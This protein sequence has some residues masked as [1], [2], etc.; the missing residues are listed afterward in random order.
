MIEPAQID[1]GTPGEP[2]RS[3]RHGDLYHPRIG[4]LEQARHV[5]LAGNGLPARWA[6]RERFTV[7][8]L[9]FGL[10]N[11]FLATWQAWRD[12]A[13]RCGRLVFVSIEKHPPRH[14]DLSRAHE[15]SPLPALAAALV[16][17]WPPLVPGMHRL[18]FEGGR[19]ELLLA[20][21]DVRTLLPRLR[22]QADAVF[23]DGFAP[24]KNPA[25]NATMW[26]PEV[27]KALAR[28]AAPGA[29]AATWSAAG[30]LRAALSAAGFEWQAAPGIGGKREI[31]QARFAPRFPVPAA[32]P[33]P[34][35]ALV[36]G[37][38]LA[39]ASAAR[40]LAQ[41]GVAVTVLEAA[42][43]AAAGAS[44]SPAGLFHG[45]VHRDDGPYARLF[46]AAAL[47]AAGE[48]AR[49]GFAPQGLLRLV[50]DD[51]PGLPATAA[52]YA[53]RV[54]GDDAAQLAGVPV[55]GPAWYFEGG[56]FVEPARWVQKALA[57]PGVTLR[58]QARAGRIGRGDDGRW[59]VFDTTGARRADADV[60]VL[61]NAFGAPPLLAA[62]GHAPWPLHG[63]RGQLTR[64]PPSSAHALRR[65]LAGD[66]YAIPLPDGTLLCG[67]TRQ[68]GDDDAAL[69]HADHAE[70]LRRLRRLT[71]ITPSTGAALSGWVGFRQHADDHLPIAGAVPLPP[72]QMPPGQRL[73]QARM[74]PREAG[75][76]VL[77]ALGARGLT[78]APLLGRLVAAQA[79]GDAWPLE[80]DLADAVDPA[81]WRVR[82]ARRA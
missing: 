49:A 63:R 24:A 77:M 37:A 46:R 20:F 7:L 61:A 15:A 27:M 2:P 48:Y 78:L 17:A 4:P 42:A 47:F 22:L 54:E 33:R 82:E 62:L 58:T 11:N 26:S 51:A 30:E 66:G 13:A 8:E 44:A 56:G 29:T 53:R 68:A 43:H 81:R 76:F 36:L 55:P 16:S 45:T 1:F 39:G 28:R 80:Q 64:L 25:L 35:D 69:R 5:F 40:A 9:G 6:G 10:G 71:G 67:A 74:L 50:D 34:R 65:P 21:G 57:T 3:P 60:L 73:D 70:N 19:V 18:A 32:P 38:G 31:T 12:D 75:L 72:S 14:E 41:Q 52:A 59:A 23:L 79:T